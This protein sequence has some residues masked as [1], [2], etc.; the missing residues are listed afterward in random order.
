MLESTLAMPTIPAALLRRL[1]VPGSLRNLGS[2]FVLAL[3]NIIAPGTIVSVG[4]IVV[5]DK[6]YGP[7]LI[8]VTG[9]GQPRPA[10]RIHAK[11][12]LDFPINQI[13]TFQ[14]A[15]APLGA[16]LHRLRVSILTREVGE[17]VV[18]AQDQ[19]ADAESSF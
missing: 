3:K 5:D 8:T 19:V 17:L 12:P 15:A 4:S 1:Y 9:R 13:V 2:G 10:D 7:E 14:V 6:A 16:G 11:S 18:E